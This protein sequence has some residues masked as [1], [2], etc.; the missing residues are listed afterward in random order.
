MKKIMILLIGIIVAGNVYAQQ[1]LP[2]KGI[3]A[4]PGEP[5]KAPAEKKK[6]EKVEAVKEKDAATITAEIEKLKKT[7]EALQKELEQL[8]SANAKAEAGSAAKAAPGSKNELL[9]KQKNKELEAR[10]KEN[11]VKAK[12]DSGKLY[13]E[14]GNAYTKAKLYKNAI[15][16]YLACLEADPKT[17]EAHYNL[18]LLYQRYQEDTNKAVIHFKKYLNSNPPPDKRREVQYLLDM[19]RSGREWVTANY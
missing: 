7:N 16:A 2:A 8:K 15:D 6:V 19:L 9:L 5:V 1:V 14:M 10:I 13:F 12:E 11:M 4:F 18:G 3:K 17:A